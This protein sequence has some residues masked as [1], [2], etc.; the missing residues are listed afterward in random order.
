MTMDSKR[1]DLSK[2]IE[3]SVFLDDGYLD[4]IKTLI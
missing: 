3:E 1:Y 4:S 2:G